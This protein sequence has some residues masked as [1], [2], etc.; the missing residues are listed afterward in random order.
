MEA[1]THSP[2]I[3]RL[4]NEMGLTVYVGNPRKLRLIWDSTDKSDARILGMVCRVEPR[5]LHPLHHRGSQA[6]T[7]LAVIKSRDMLVKSRTQL[8]SHARGLIKANGG[9]LPKCSTA[10]F[11]KRRLFN[12]TV[13]LS[14]HSPPTLQSSKKKIREWLEKNK[15][16]C[17]KDCLKPELVEVLKKVAPEP[18]YAIDELATVY[19]H[20]VLRTPP[21]HPELQPIETCWGVVKNY[22]AKHCNFTMK[23]LIKQLDNGFRKVTRETCTAIVKRIQEKEDEL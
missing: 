4:L 22:I 6:Q 23:N 8:V 21:Y 19:G 11:A 1:G 18:I 12:T 10:S 3:S 17:R 2:W 20:K 16:Y 15:I 9:R 7:D 5:L 13:K 14:E